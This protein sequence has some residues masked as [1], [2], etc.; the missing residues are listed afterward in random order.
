MSKR[1]TGRRPAARAAAGP[2]RYLQYR[3]EHTAFRGIDH[4]L[5]NLMWMLREAFLHGRLAVLPRL[6]LAPM[7]NFG[8]AAGTGQWDKYFDLDAS[9]L[10]D[11]LGA[12]HPLPLV[13]RLPPGELRTLE[14]AHRAPMPA[15]AGEFDLVV[16]PIRY[17]VH[18]HDLP[19]Q[20]LRKLVGGVLS[21]KHPIRF[22]FRPSALV[23]GLAEPVVGAL[24][25]KHGSY[26]AAHV[27]RGDRLQSG[28]RYRRRTAPQSVRRSL[29]RLGVREGAPVFF[30]SDE[31]NPDYWAPLADRYTAVRYTDFPHLKALVAGDRAPDNYLLYEVEKA[32]MAR[33]AIRLRSM[34]VD[35]RTQWHASLVSRWDWALMSVFRKW[36]EALRRRRLRKGCHVADAPAGNLCG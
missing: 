10:V 12:R 20:R 22:D 13:R 21:G 16:R 23:S 17:F 36:R 7:H 18:L 9:R 32:V 26:A 2:G 24:L 33:A 27:R 8:S 11:P 31:R 28:A 6:N 30:A 3:P 14:L 15:Q 19:H 35:A 5:S 1:K 25:S 4:E 29:D 34:P